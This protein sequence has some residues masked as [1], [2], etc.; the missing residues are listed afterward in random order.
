MSIWNITL[1]HK[2]LHQKPKLLCE[3]ELNSLKARPGGSNQRE[4]CLRGSHQSRPSWFNQ[5]LL[6]CIRTHQYLFELIVCGK[7]KTDYW[8][9]STWCSSTHLWKKQLRLKRN[10]PQSNWLYLNMESIKSL[11][12]GS[13]W[14]LPHCTRSL[15][16]MVSFFVSFHTFNHW[17]FRPALHSSEHSP[18]I[19]KPPVYKE[20]HKLH[21]NSNLACIFTH[22]L[23]LLQ[24]EFNPG[25]QT[26]N[27]NYSDWSHSDMN[28]WMYCE[29]LH[30]FKHISTQQHVTQSGL[31][32]KTG[33]SQNHRSWVKKVF[34]FRHLALS[35]YT[36]KYC[37]TDSWLTFMDDEEAMCLHHGLSHMQLFHPHTS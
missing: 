25:T 24:F 2:L 28:L 35:A 26:C 30:R 33:F 29:L 27:R 3:Q 8:P 14:T 4:S 9:V 19:Y 6:V 32:C 15:P 22:I 20:N 36:D 5:S 13:F 10:I 1:V 18:I 7:H 31:D 21:S 11:L 23:L 34:G 17:H 16:T 37:D 12:Q